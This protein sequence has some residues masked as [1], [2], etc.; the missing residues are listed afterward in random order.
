MARGNKDLNCFNEPYG[1]KRLEMGVYLGHESQIK[2]KI[3]HKMASDG[4]SK[5]YHNYTIVWAPGIGKIQQKNY[6][7]P[8]NKHSNT[9]RISFCS[10]TGSHSM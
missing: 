1:H 3:F 10:Q 9:I 5:D 6:L 4:W 7:V 8:T 2:R